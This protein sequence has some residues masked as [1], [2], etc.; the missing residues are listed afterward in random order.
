MNRFLKLKYT[1]PIILIAIGFFVFSFNLGNELFWDDDDW[2]LNNQFV[3]SLSLDNVKFWLT[4]NTLAGVGLRSN[5]YRPFLFFTFSLNYVISE[6]KPWSYHLFSNAIHLIN[7]VLIFW[8]LKGIFKRKLYAFLAAL[9]FI[10][11][12]L[13]TEAI[14]YISGRGDSLVAMFMLFSLYLFY[15]SEINKSS[16]LSF[17]KIASLVSLV[18]GLLSRETGI[19]F[20]F[21]ALILYISFISK[22]RFILS[23]KKGLIKTW[24]YFATVFVY[25]ILRLTTLNFLNTLNFYSAPNIYS[26]NLHVRMFTFAHTVLT[27]LKL[28]IA[29]IGLHMERSVP[30]H[31]SLFQWPVWVSFLGIISLL[32]WLWRLYKRE[33][34]SIHNTK[35]KPE[36]YH[37]F[38]ANIS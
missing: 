37:R 38:S 26:E 23:I 1:L 9:I 18:L 16:W 35:Y 14:T 28:L 31:T 11:H 21:L 15:K 36:A 7:G 34:S 24:P 27:Y 5:Y 29:P 17:I 6:I 4:N 32:I 3:H 13:Q 8:L 25:G 22:D 20:P 10:I 19:I 30:I 2:I 33:K 12:P